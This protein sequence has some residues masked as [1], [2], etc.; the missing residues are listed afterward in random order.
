MDIYKINKSHINFQVPWQIIR[1]L[2]ILR[3][4]HF[5]PVF[6]MLSQQTVIISVNVLTDLFLVENEYDFLW[7]YNW[8][9]V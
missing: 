5:T 2:F 9:F 4:S 6:V 7:K 1:L 3:T 8:Y